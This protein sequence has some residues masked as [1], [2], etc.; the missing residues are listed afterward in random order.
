MWAV[1]DSY[2]I[3]LWCN[4]CCYGGRNL[5]LCWWRCFSDMPLQ[6]SQMMPHQIMPVCLKTF[7]KLHHV[8]LLLKSSTATYLHCVQNWSSKN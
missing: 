5:Q 8:S 6:Q 3:A 2:S 4:W 1:G 7:N